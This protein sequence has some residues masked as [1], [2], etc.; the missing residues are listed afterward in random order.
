M[1]SKEKKELIVFSPI[2]IL[3][4]LVFSFALFGIT[5]ARVALGIALVSLPFYLV[6]DNFELVEGEKI[7]FSI[8][9]GLSVFPS[10]AYLLGL[11]LSFRIALAVAFITFIA[12]AVIL[13]KYKTKKISN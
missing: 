8:L 12:T 5:G 2:V 1:L 10:L 3:I 11:V 7:V 13:G 6:I 4:A 9:L